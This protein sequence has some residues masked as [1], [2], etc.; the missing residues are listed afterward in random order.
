MK[1][2]K[3]SGVPLKRRVAFR[4]QHVGFVFVTMCLVPTMPFVL[5]W[6]FAHTS[7]R[8]FLE[9]VTAVL[10]GRVEAIEAQRDELVKL[11]SQHGSL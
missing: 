6:A 3:Q 8:A 7:G 10:R 1:T 5:L 4:M 2:L 11:Y 9:G